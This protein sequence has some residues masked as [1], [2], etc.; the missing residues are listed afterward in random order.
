MGSKKCGIAV[1]T[2]SLLTAGCASPQPVAA[3][4]SA[5]QKLTEQTVFA[6]NWMQQ[7]GEISALSYQAFN[8]AQ[9]A[10]DQAKAKP[11]FNKAVVVD[12]D[13]TM[14]DNSAY[15]GWQIKHRQPYSDATWSKWNQAREAKALPGAVDF[16]HYVVEHGGQIFYVSNRA[17]ADF[18][19]TVDNLKALNFA[20]VGPDTVLLKPAGGSTN[21][22]ERFSAVEKRGFDIVVYVGDNLNDF[23]GEPYHQLNTQRRDFVNRHQ[24]DFG[25]K[26]I[27]LPNPSYGDWE[28]G[29]AEGYFK[30]NDEGKVKIREARI[31]AWDGK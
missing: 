6:V 23:S 26:Y 9:T 14:I 21:K 4:E 20:N 10:F 16:S 27:M 8:T 11:G 2:L 13:E 17:Q 22:V 25:R 19:A 15:A 1:V 31:D 24:E 28:G 29:M 5:Q 18:A 7:S 12:I 3:P 30:L